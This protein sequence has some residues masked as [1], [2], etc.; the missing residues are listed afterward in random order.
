MKKWRKGILVLIT[1]CMV[2][3]TPLTIFAH[4][5]A[6]EHN[7]ELEAVLLGED[8]SKYKVKET[9][10]YIEDASYLTID[11]WSS[12]K[13]TP[14]GEEKFEELKSAGKI[15]RFLKFE[16]IDYNAKILGKNVTGKIHRVHTHQG[17]KYSSG[18]KKIDIFLKNRR[19]ILLSTLDEVFSFDDKKIGNGFI[20]GHSD[21]CNALAGIIYYVHILGD[22]DEAEKKESIGKLTDLAG[23]NDG[24]NMI[25]ELI[26]YCEILFSSQKKSCIYKKLIKELKNI[27]K[28]ASKLLKSEGGI[29]DE[30]FNEYHE[31]TAEVMQTLKDNIPS[32]LK[33]E[34][35]FKEVFYSN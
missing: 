35:F 22:Y 6:S 28:S 13:D 2:L 19:E 18:L 24:N 20:T 34:K 3:H 30:K 9:I 8:Y 1:I 15:S 25:S 4:N 14:T 33:N 27:E 17:W 7:K 26:E 29:T 32:L 23:R 11:Q 12:S 10:T 21:K 16:S 31:C 5:K